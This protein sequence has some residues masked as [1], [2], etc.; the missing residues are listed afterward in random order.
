MHGEAWVNIAIQ[1]ADLLIACGMRF[2]D[3]VTGKLKTYAPHAKKIHIEID[4]SEI[5]KNVTVDVALVGDLRAV[6]ERLLPRVGRG[7][8]RRL[9]ARTSTRCKGDAAVRDI[10]SLPDDGHLYAAHVIHDLWRAHQ[11]A[12]RS[13]SPTSASTRCGRRSTTTTNR[14]ARSSPRADSARWASR[15]RRRSAPSCARPDEEV[16]AVVGDGG[17]QM[18]MCELATAVQEGINDQGRDHQQRLS[19]HGAP[20]AGVL[21]RAAL[22]GDAA[23]RARLREAGRGVRHRGPRST[24]RAGRGRRRRRGARH[25]GRRDRLPRR[26][27]RHGVSDGA[28][29]R[30]SARDDP[31]AHRSWRRRPTEK[32][33][34][35]RAEG[36]KGRKWQGEEALGDGH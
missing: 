20:V 22:R 26:A 9:A 1:Q 30:R 31:P 27:G 21:L 19:R 35:H 5:N 17:F 32:G 11:A 34:G 14:R 6:L 23:R 36:Y 16:W 7:D 2:D 25:E 33:R 28:G 3:R 15:C 24:T 29:R 8:A 13:S 10:Q 4:P 12:T 18:T